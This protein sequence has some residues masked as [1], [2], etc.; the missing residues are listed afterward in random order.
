MLGLALLVLYRR[1]L[2]RHMRRVVAAGY[3]A[4]QENRP[5]FCL[6]SGFSDARPNSVATVTFPAFATPIL[7]WATFAVPSLFPLLFLNRTVRAIG[8]VLLMFGSV[9]FVGWS[10]AI[11]RL[12]MLIGMR[13]AQ[14]VFD[15]R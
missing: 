12:G 11:V 9:V 14:W 15:S 2:G 8:P 7:L 5:P 4:D 10:I 1:A 6:W 13:T 3:A